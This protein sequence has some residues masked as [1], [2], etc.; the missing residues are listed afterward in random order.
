[1]NLIYEVSSA[2]I[3]NTYKVFASL[4][5]DNNFTYGEQI[6]RRDGS[7]V[8]ANGAQQTINQFAERA[9]ANTFFRNGA[10][11]RFEPGA[12][13]IAITECGWNPFKDD[14][15]VDVLKISRL[16]RILEFISKKYN[17]RATI[18]NYLN[19]KTLDELYTACAD[20]LQKIKDDQDKEIETQSFDNEH[21]Y[22]IV[23]ID[24][25]DESKKYHDLTNPDSPWCITYDYANYR[26][27][28]Q[29]QNYA[30]YFCIRDDINEVERKIGEN[31]P[32]DDYGKSLLCV[33]VDTEGDLE[34]FT[35]RW[36]HKDAN[37]KTVKADKGLGD[38]VTVSKIVGVNFNKVFKPYTEEELKAIKDA[39]LS[40]ESLTKSNEPGEQ[41]TA[42]MD[43][44]YEYFDNQNDELD[45]EESEEYDISDYNALF[46]LSEKYDEENNED[47]D[48]YKFDFAECMPFGK[49]AVISTII[50]YYRLVD[51]HNK[52]LSNW[53]D[54]LIMTNNN[55]YSAGNKYVLFFTKEHGQNFYTVNCLTGKK[56][57]ISE[58]NGHKI[59]K[60]VS[61]VD[62]KYT[63]SPRFACTL[64][65]NSVVLI[66]ACNDKINVLQRINMPNDYRLVYELWRMGSEPNN[67]VAV[68]LLKNLETGK[69][70][71]G[72][73]KNN[74]KPMLKL[75]DE[76]DEYIKIHYNSGYD[77]RRDLFCFK[78]CKKENSQQEQF[79]SFRL[80]KD[81]EHIEYIVD[82]RTNDIPLTTR[83]NTS[84]LIY[85]SKVA[86]DSK[87]SNNIL[88]K[89]DVAISTDNYI[90]L[91][92][93][94]VTNAMIHGWFE[95]IKSEKLRENNI[96]TVGLYIKDPN[97]T[98]YV[99]FDKNGK[100]IYTDK[101]G[102]KYVPD[103]YK[104]YAY[105]YSNWNTSLSLII[106]NKDNRMKI[107][108]ISFKDLLN[109]MKSESTILRYAA[110]LC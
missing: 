95:E 55:M 69:Y 46:E 64:D 76:G 100:T 19:N 3:K 15:D 67:F 42:Y 80:S 50:G 36:N 4:L 45:P 37:G 33:I 97:T 59:V 92:D 29:R 79:L 89:G 60:I 78:Y 12:A 18:D 31:C 24:S 57:D 103:K 105:W 81:L 74:F 73:S 71:L 90:Y 44:I 35:T 58:L 52:Y 39:E 82:K 61:A 21:T 13:R 30:M 98:E 83:D 27:Y 38:K 5:F 77:I 34:T 88:Y 99:V 43:A 72:V 68:Y 70:N 66:A 102:E 10:D 84:V 14:S 85:N 75:E 8:L 40:F 32:L 106:A 16:K 1:M 49:Y 2:V 22:K 65:D 86:Y 47:L 93:V 101:L 107:K 28:T 51:F 108:I 20:E 94:Y 23:R 48:D 41:F 54:E 7:P 63:T 6:M 25:F 109:N 9:L 110:Y 62:N 96:D 56:P 53:C 11:R 17:D 91:K 104:L 87:N 26:T